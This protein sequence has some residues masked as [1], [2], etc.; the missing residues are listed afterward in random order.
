MHA[1]VLHTQKNHNY[2]A[3]KPPASQYKN[4]SLQNTAWQP[5]EISIF[6]KDTSYTAMGL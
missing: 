1:V 3:T 5:A 6:S 2:R 4:C